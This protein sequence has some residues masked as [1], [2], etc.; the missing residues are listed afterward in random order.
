MSEVFFERDICLER[1]L[2]FERNIQ[3]WRDGLRVKELED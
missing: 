2:G 3:P 1:N